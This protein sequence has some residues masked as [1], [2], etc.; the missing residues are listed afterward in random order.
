QGIAENTR[1]LRVSAQGG[2]AAVA[3][4]MGA[5]G[6]DHELYNRA[7][8]RI[9]AV[10]DGS[11]ALTAGMVIVNDGGTFGVAT[12]EGEGRADA[13]A[14]SLDGGRSF[15]GAAGMLGLGAEVHLHNTTDAEVAASAHGDVAVAA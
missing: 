15:A 3:F 10:A 4:G 12:N 9:E 11:V 5:Q 2:S 7:D 1:G 13:L 14:S 6:A 8:G